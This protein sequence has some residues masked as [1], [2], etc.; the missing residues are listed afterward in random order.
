MRPVP[1]LADQADE[2]VIEIKMQ[3][4][5]G[6]D[7][8]MVYTA[9]NRIADFFVAPVAAFEKLNSIVAAAL[10]KGGRN[11]SKMIVLSGFSHTLS[12]AAQGALKPLHLTVFC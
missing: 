10:G 12:R 3:Y 8:L 2:L 5:I 11:G 7:N 4:R 1:L 6:G 9:A